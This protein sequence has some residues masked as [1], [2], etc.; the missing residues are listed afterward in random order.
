M[1]WSPEET[2]WLRTH[3]AKLGP[4]ACAVHL[5]RTLSSVGS[6]AF[7]LRLRHQAD[8]TRAQEQWLSAHYVQLGPTACAAHLGRTVYAVT[9][10]AQR[11]RIAPARPDWTAEEIE[12][13]R[14]AYPEEGARPLVEDLGKSRAAIAQKAAQL[15]LRLDRGAALAAARKLYYRGWSD[16]CIGRELNHSRKWFQRLRQGPARRP[17]RCPNCKRRRAGLSGPAR[18]YGDT[19]DDD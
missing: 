10:K 18:N 1:P 3:Y 16:A 7:K 19:D 9:R 8:W 11:L 14:E 15:G 2:A 17:C 13:L 5:G 4:T 6:R 12:I